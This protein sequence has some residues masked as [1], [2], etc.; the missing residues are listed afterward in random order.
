MEH[1]K[2]NEAG[3]PDCATCAFFES[4]RLS[5]ECWA[6]IAT[7]QAI[8]LMAKRVEEAKQKESPLTRQIGG[9]HYKGTTIQPSEYIL[10]NNLNF[11][12]GNIVKRITRRKGGL[13]KRIED[14]NKLKHEADILIHYYETGRLKWE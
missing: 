8:S 5:R 14:L 7:S 3:S 9:D 4:E 11:W 1:D 10:A 12:E 2:P 13:D 6:C